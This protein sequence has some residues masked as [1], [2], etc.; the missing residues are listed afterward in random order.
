MMPSPKIWLV[1]IWFILSWRSGNSSCNPWINLFVASLKKTPDLVAG[2]RI[3]IEES[4]RMWSG[5]RSSSWLATFGGVNTS[6]FDRFASASS[7]SGLC[8]L[9]IFLVMEG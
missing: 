9:L 2:S 4:D 3:L 6:S 8:G 7:T 1:R 5:R